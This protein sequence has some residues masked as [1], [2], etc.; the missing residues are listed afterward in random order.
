M[1]FLSL[2]K[3][4]EVPEV[5]PTRPVVVYLEGKGEPHRRSW[6]MTGAMC[7]RKGLIKN[8]FTFEHKWLSGLLQQ[9]SDLALDVPKDSHGTRVASHEIRVYCQPEM[10]SSIKGTAKRYGHR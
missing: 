8:S 2:P 10:F 6:K 4:L 5:G 9:L 3:D 7:V 1:L